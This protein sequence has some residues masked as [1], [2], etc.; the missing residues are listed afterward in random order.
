MIYDLKNPLDRA[1]LNDKIVLYTI[2]GSIVT[3]TEKAHKTPNQNKYAHLLIG[4][5]ALATGNSLEDTKREYFKKLVN[6]GIFMEYKTDKLGNQIEVCKSFTEISKED[7]TLA[8]DR[9]KRWG[10]EN[11][12]TMPEPGDAE[13]LRAIEFEIERQKQYL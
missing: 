1:Q 12:I 9:F 2:K 4:V 8:I 5:V 7:L 13:L 6:P 10:A 3:L 11:H